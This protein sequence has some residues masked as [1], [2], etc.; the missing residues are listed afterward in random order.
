MIVAIIATKRIAKL[1][2]RTHQPDV[3][4]HFILTVGDFWYIVYLL[5]LLSALNATVSCLSDRFKCLNNRCI[6]KGWVCDGDFD[7]MDNATSTSPSS[8]EID[9]GKVLFRCHEPC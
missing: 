5:L 6:P 8:D 1:N 2:V 3:N 9:C 7:C 4:S